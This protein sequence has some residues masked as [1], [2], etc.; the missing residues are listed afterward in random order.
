MDYTFNRVYLK[1]FG[2]VIKLIIGYKM[3]L[4]MKY[5]KRYR[6]FRCLSLFINIRK[7]LLFSLKK[8]LRTNFL[9]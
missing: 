2:I 4:V 8:K 5:V 6:R 9:C 1:K 7:G 3:L